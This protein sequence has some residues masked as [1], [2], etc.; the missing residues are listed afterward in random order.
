[1]T[2]DSGQASSVQDLW[3]TLQQSLAYQPGI[4]DPCISA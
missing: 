2:F 3:G 1:M 4:D